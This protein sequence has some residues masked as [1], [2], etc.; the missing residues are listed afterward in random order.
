MVKL[1]YTQCLWFYHLVNIALKA[2]TL[3]SRTIGATAYGCITKAPL[4]AIR[5]LV[6]ISIINLDGIAHTDPLS[7][8]RNISNHICL[9]SSVQPHEGRVPIHN[10]DRSQLLHAF[11]SKKRSIDLVYWGHVPSCISVVMSVLVASLWCSGRHRDTIGGPPKCVG[12]PCRPPLN[13]LTRKQHS[14]SCY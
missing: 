14:S 12:D 4:V 9:S 13:H 8:D 10:R 3:S 1:V 7:I 11:F 2:S 5:R 6:S